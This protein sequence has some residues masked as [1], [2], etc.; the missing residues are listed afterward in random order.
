LSRP[1]TT[2]QE[3]GGRW[4]TEA[5]SGLN[6]SWA[7]AQG[8]IAWGA[9]LPTGRWE[10]RGVRREN[11]SLGLTEHGELRVTRVVRVFFN[12]EVENAHAEERT[13][14]R[15]RVSVVE[16]WQVVSHP[17]FKR[18]SCFKIVHMGNESCIFCLFQ[19]KPEICILR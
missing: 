9:E 18:G 15:Q 14:G 12:S 7:E 8:S 1:C 13:C 4:A 3:P 19:E 17:P 5:C 6:A 2:P 16:M 10:G 11:T